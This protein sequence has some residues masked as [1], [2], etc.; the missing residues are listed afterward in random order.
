MSLRRRA[1]NDCQLVYLVDL[2]RSSLNTWKALTTTNKKEAISAAG[3][4]F[5]PYQ[6]N[7]NS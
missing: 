6:M 1:I 7:P 4:G 5:I 3:T 2:G